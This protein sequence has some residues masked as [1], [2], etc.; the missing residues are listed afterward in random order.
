VDLPPLVGVLAGKPPSFSEAVAPL[1]GLL[2]GLEV[3]VGQAAVFARMRGAADGLREDEVAALY[4]YT[5]ESP[6]YRQ[7][8]VALRHPDR[9]KVGPYLG[10]LRLFFAA[11]SRL[12]EHRR[13]LYRG[14]ALDLSPR[15]PEGRVVTWWGVSSCTPRLE[16][17]RSFLGSKGKRTLF[18]VVPLRAVGIRAFSAFT[19]EEE[20]VL[21][22]GTR[23]RVLSSQAEKDGLCTIR[24]GELEG[25]RMVS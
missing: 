9:K 2:P 4:L 12:K 22:P 8:N 25:E 15:Y 7:L 17:A 10:Y 18:E 6:F 24:M 1:L 14:V 21:P 5:T 20:Y 16:V 11:S 23:L 3:S 13:S 19:E